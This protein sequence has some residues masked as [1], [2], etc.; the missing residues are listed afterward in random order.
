MV[1]ESYGMIPAKP[2]GYILSDGIPLDLSDGVGAFELGMR[3]DGRAVG[4]CIQ[5]LQDEVKRL[6]QLV[7][8]REQEKRAFAG[9]VVELLEVIEWR[10]ARPSSLDVCACCNGVDLKHESGCGFVRLL[11]LARKV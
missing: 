11:D 4:A 10:A 5:V 3:L 2:Y 1:I 8:E 7:T 9:E 6:Q